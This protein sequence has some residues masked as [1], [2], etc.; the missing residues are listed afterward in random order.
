MTDD[1]IPEEPPA[2]PAEG[3]PAL[4]R[5]SR[6]RVV[7]G[8]CG[9]LGRYLDIDPVVFR[10]VIAVLGLTGGLGLFLYGLAWLVVPREA[11]DGE[12]GRTELQ[13]VLTGRVDGQSVGAVLVTV[14]GTGV[15]FS[16]MGDGGQL[17]P[18]LLL[19]A[20][21]FLALRYDPERRRRFEGGG[22]G[23]A[24][25]G[26]T[27]PRDRLEDSGPFADWK[28]W[29]ESVGRD[30]RAEW[31][32]R[33]AELQE[34]LRARHAEHHGAGGGAEYGDTPPVGPSGYLWDPRHPERDPYGGATPPY[35]TPARP[36]WQR[37]DLPEGDPLRKEPREDAHRDRT[38]RR[39]ADFEERA[40]RRHEA[41]RQARE[42]H[43]AHHEWRARRRAERGTPVLGASAV[44]VAVGASWAVAADDHGAHR[45]STVLAVALL[46]L[47]LAMLLSAR[48]GRTRGLTFLSLLLTAGLV[49]AAGTSATVADSTGDRAWT[50]TAADLPARYTLG[51][52]HARLD[53]SALDPRGGTLATELRVGA[54]SA[55]VTVPAGVELRLKLRD[56]VGDV[57]LP[58]GQ[59][60]DGPFTHEDVVIEVPEGQPS[61]GA[62]ELTVTV[63]AG[64]IEVVR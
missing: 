10:V 27:G 54:G 41:H 59:S 58:D 44:L 51:A 6:H 22:D 35:G 23:P 63:G 36:W 7:A 13:R 9:G 56:G 32:V 39:T 18:L 15:F 49:L 1:Q 40:G 45:W 42:R 64:D 24:P 48:W 21:V 20:L 12:G 53:L 25:A 26:S 33:G 46:P 50:A 34:R 16:S 8:V 31:K 17:F 57:R 61:R 14:I 52:G 4:T 3:R 29:S 55:R 43:R 30:L 62:L 19:A 37:T 38:D 5:S 60:F 2:A 28:T 47:G 11:A